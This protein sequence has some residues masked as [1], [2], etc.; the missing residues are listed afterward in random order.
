MANLSNV[1]S[2]VKGRTITQK[3]KAKKAA[4]TYNPYGFSGKTNIFMHILL[5]SFSFLCIFPFIY[6]IIISLTSEQSLA[7]NGYSIFPQEWSLEAYRY[8]KTMKDQLLSA[9]GVTLLVT[10]LGTLISVSIISLY[11]YAISRKQFIYRKQF[12]FIAFF[13]MLFS[14]G[15]VPFFIVVTQ[16]LDLKNTIWA[17]ILPLAVNAFYIII[18]RTFFQQSVPEAIL[19]SARIDGAGEFRIFLQIVVP[20]AVPGIA[21]IALFSTLAYWNDWFNAL[22]FID[23]PNLVPLQS[24]LMKIEN[25]L[26]FIKQNSMMSQNS[27]LLNS[28]PQD[29]VKMAIVV[30]ATL[31]IALSY[32]FF[33]KY[34]VKGLTIGGVKE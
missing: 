8:L 19:E 11:S 7:Q 28:I 27:S 26:D 31:P 33:Q 15:L 18:M 20:L 4:K 17:L 22:L 5:A 12:T 25:N 23:N 1:S 21:T 9:F 6:V 34:F 13:T 10:V 2:Q 3:E 32:P 16:F 24:L 30:I 14:G 29:S